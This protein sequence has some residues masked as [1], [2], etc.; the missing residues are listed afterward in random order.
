MD[1]HL[2]I[3][4]A[5]GVCKVS[6]KS[7]SGTGSEMLSLTPVL[8]KYLRDLVMPAGCARPFVESTLAMCTVVS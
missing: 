7:I 6:D 5:R 4:D 8:A 1:M 3:H 2:D